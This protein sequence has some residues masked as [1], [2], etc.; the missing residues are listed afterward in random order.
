MTYLFIPSILI[1]AYVVT[2]SSSM[3][4]DRYKKRI[5]L[6]IL[7][8]IFGIVVEIFSNEER[9]FSFVIVGFLPLI[10][11]F[12]YEIF[13]CLFKPLIGKFPYSP[14]REKIG[15]K[16]SGF[17]YPKNRKVKFADYLFGMILL[18]LPI[19]TSILLSILLNHCFNK[20]NF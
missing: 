11:L 8:V 3:L 18:F 19:L 6:S 13:R 9:R 2:I 12:Y 16:V 20:N 15:T 1:Y 5:L 7:S 17:G 4:N 14:N 10:Y